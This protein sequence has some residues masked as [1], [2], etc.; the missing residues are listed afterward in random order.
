MTIKML[1]NDN[2][3]VILAATVLA[4]EESIIDAMIVAETMTGIENY[5]SDDITIRSITRRP[6]KIQPLNGSIVP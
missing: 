2:L 6:E 3:D 4:V 5:K 1:P